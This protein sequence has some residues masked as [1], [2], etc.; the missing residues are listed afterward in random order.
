MNIG[1]VIPSIR[2][3]KLK[4]FFQKWNI[5]SEDIFVYV[6]E[7]NPE[8]S[9][10]LE[11]VGDNFYIQHYSW[12]E[13]KDELGENAWIISQKSDAIRSFGFYRAYKDDCSEIITLDDDCFPNKEEYESFTGFLNGHLEK[14]IE[15]GLKWV[16]TTKDIKARG[17]PFY[18]LGNKEV[19]INMGF[20][21]N[22]ADFDAP[23]QLIHGAIEVEPNILDPVPVGQYFPMSGM[24]LSFK[25]EI[26]P[27]M[28][29]PLMGQGYEYDRFGDI[30]CGIIAKKICD[31][32]GFSITAGSPSVI[33]DKASN[34]WLNL[35]KEAK[36][37]SFNEDFWEIVDKI[38]LKGRN[39]SDCYREISEVFIEE[40]GYLNTLG[41]AM[42]V[43]VE[44]LK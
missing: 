21:R 31:H 32:L 11:D 7:D 14:L 24:N 15:P 12:K 35:Q 33:H 3:N 5:K 20:W 22:V 19:V 26:V 4:E 8:K 34:V 2:E 28:Y 40:G 10:D 17:V 6:V 43:W 38:E 36:G 25:R 30:W 41:K 16:W 42:K 9:F 18:N 13:I 37:L 1:L 39:I 29:F 44:I 23:T 27:M